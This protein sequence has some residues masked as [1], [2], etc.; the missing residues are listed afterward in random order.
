MYDL[1]ARSLAV[2]DFGF[3]LV[4]SCPL[5]I[6]IQPRLLLCAEHLWLGLQARH[7]GKMPSRGTGA[8][9]QNRRLFCYSPSLRPIASL[10]SAI[11]FSPRANVEVHPLGLKFTV[12]QSKSIQG[13]QPGLSSSR[14]GAGST[15]MVKC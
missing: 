4:G 12:E 8:A 1:K 15:R 7:T 10:L 2:I 14:R 3:R 11:S 6:D 13:G 5:S 9:A